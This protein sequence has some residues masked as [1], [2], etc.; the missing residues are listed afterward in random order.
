[1]AVQIKPY[2]VKHLPVEGEVKHGDL[3]FFTKEQGERQPDIAGKVGKANFDGYAVDKYYYL[4][5]KK[6]KLFLCS[7]D[8]QVG[9]KVLDEEFCEWTVV[10]SDL[11]NPDVL[12]KVMGEISSEAKW[13]KEGDEFDESQIQKWAKYKAIWGD[14]PVMIQPHSWLKVVND[15]KWTEIHFRIKCPCCE[16]FK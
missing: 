5:N 9:D 15:Q 1:M 16:T 3:F 2:F 12:T 11:K 7:R 4:D 8:I 14:H 13:V 6:A 10:E